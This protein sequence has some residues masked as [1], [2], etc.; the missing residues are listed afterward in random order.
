MSSKILFLGT[1]TGS[2]Q[3]KQVRSA[4][5]IYIYSHGYSFLLDPGPGSLVKS[6]ESGINLRKLTSVV[7]SHG[8]VNHCSDG[9]SIISAMSHNGLDPRGVLIC[10]KTFFSGSE[11]L[12]P[13]LTNYHKTCVERIITP[14]EGSKIGI[15][16]LEIHTLKT[17]H[18]D[19]NSLGFKFFTPDFVLSYTGDTGYS[20]EAVEQYMQSDILILN[21]PYYDE[22]V[23][24]NLNKDKVLKILKK[25]QPKLAI[26][27]HLGSDVV[28]NDPIEVGREI[29]RES[30]VQTIVAKDGL[31]LTPTSY[32]AGLKQRTLNL[33]ENEETTSNSQEQE[34]NQQDNQQSGKASQDKND[35]SYL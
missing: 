34:D 19:P 3:S 26:V 1:G 30:G 25:V 2:P 10:S 28:K 22:K 12:T 6:R 9:N 4:G 7:I 24:G 31:E 23:S 32:S 27:T 17:E 5:G 20:K 8:H 33:F 35:L 13:L 21:M 18:T 14:N 16:S 11:D 29:K 15:E